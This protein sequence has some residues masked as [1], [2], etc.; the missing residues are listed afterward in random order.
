MQLH[1]AQA[2][3][4]QAPP[5]L[6][7]GQASSAVQLR[8]SQLPQ[9]PGSQGRRNRQVGGPLDCDGWPGS[10][11]S[12][13]GT[14]RQ[15]LHLG[16][17]APGRGGAIFL[18]VPG[19]TH[20][21]LTAKGPLGAFPCATPTPTPCQAFQALQSSGSGLGP[22]SCGSLGLEGHAVPTHLEAHLCPQA[23]V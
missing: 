14:W 20:R 8:C 12:P 15:E 13:G 5:H 7:W 11:A 23:G 9:S 17:G 3:W 19:A 21:L 2:L 22:S 18:A 6:P 1:C 16:G 4:P 10:P